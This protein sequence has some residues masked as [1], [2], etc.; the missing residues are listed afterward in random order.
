MPGRL[1]GGQARSLRL[2]TARPPGESRLGW[3]SPD[4]RFAGLPCVLGRFLPI[5]PLPGSLA[6]GGFEGSLRSTGPASTLGGRFGSLTLD[7]YPEAEFNS[8]A[9]STLRLPPRCAQ[10]E[11]TLAGTWKE[12]ARSQ[13]LALRH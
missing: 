12:E 8:P 2:L 1:R 11:G 5:Q 13:G 6:L 4:P 7:T 10:P 3:G 9:K